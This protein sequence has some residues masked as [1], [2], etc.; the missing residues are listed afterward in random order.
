MSIVKEKK[1]LI[2]EAIKNR[3]RDSEFCVFADFSGISVTEFN[4]LRR[5]MR[6]LKAQVC[7]YKNTLLKRSVDALEIDVDDKVFFGA[8]VLVN[9]NDVVSEICKELIKFGETKKKK[10]IK[11]GILEKKAVNRSELKELAK[12]PAKE[13]LIGQFFSTVKAPVDR[14]GYILSNHIV[15]L[16]G[17]LD[18]LKTKKKEEEKND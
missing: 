7:V 2:I 9:G 14:L 6:K 11:G 8:T 12:L 18:A 15:S 10:M 4:D 16:L 17:V 13:I 1:S 5:Q 3:V